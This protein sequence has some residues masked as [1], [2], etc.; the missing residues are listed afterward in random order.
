MKLRALINVFNVWPDFL[1][2]LFSE[3]DDFY[4]QKQKDRI[5]TDFQRGFTKDL[6][7]NGHVINVEVRINLCRLKVTACDKLLLSFKLRVFSAFRLFP[8]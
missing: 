5:I 6:F 3:N 7:E 2:P 1:Q 4:F 8:F